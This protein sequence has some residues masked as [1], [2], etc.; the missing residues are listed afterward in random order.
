MV[1]V[2]VHLDWSLVALSVV[3]WPHEVGV[4]KKTVITTLV[5]DGQVGRA[6]I[7]TTVGREG[8]TNADEPGS[9]SSCTSGSGRK[10]SRRP[11][12]VATAPRVWSSVRTA[13]C[14]LGCDGFL[15][16]VLIFRNRFRPLSIVQMSHFTS[17]IVGIGSV[18]NLGTAYTF[19]K[20]CLFAIF[21]G[22]DIEMMT[23]VD[24][25]LRSAVVDGVSTARAV[26]VSLSRDFEE[27][28]MKILTER[29]HSFNTTAARDFQSSFPWGC[30]S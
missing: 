12:P 20:K 24:P 5:V 26:R 13:A 17:G 27:R 11:L 30:C 8:C 25:V 15:M 9:W 4:H 2:H 10:T 22:M 7:K 21:T 28:P 18:P 1:V 6:K 16:G 3:K 29:E 14:G 19:H 23:E